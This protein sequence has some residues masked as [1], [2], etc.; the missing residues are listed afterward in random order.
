MLNNLIRRAGISVEGYFRGNIFLWFSFVLFTFVSH[1]PFSIVIK[2]IIEKR[3]GRAWGSLYF[4]S[5]NIVLFFLFVVFLEAAKEYRKKNKL[6]VLDNY[7]L[8]IVV[9]LLLIFSAA[10]WL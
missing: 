1:L 2:F 4:L 9:Y 10:L 3:F 5:A 8:F 6:I 7:G